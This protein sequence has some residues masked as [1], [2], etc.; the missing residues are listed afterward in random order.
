L[1]LPKKLKR[2]T[3]DANKDVII[4]ANNKRIKELEDENKKLKNE[5]MQLR[6]KLYD[7]GL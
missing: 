5:L 3:S 4:V 1:T 7:L 2:E 6:G